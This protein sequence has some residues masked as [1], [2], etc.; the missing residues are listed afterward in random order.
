M[1]LGS[2]EDIPGS[3]C[4]TPAFPDPVVTDPDSVS[5]EYQYICIDSDLLGTI[6]WMLNII[7]STLL[8]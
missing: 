8:S 7:K 3:A 5:F 2:G 4:S 1:E 6:K